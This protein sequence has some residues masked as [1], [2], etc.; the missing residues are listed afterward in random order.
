MSDYAYKKLTAGIVLNDISFGKDAARVADSLPEFR[1]LTTDGDYISRTDL[2][3]RPVLIAFGSISCPMTA[4]AM[5]ALKRLHAQFGDAV[6][7]LMLDVREAHPGENIEQ[8]DTLEAKCRNAT[9]LKNQYGLEFPVAVDDLDGSVHRALGT[10]PNAVFL[11]DATGTIVFRALWASD[12]K[13]LHRAL[14][15]VAAGEAPPQEQSTAMI[16]PF[17]K[18]LGYF[19]A[20]LK[21]AG[22]RAAREV[23]LAAPPIALLAGISRLFPG[24]DPGHRGAAAMASLAIV[25]ALLLIVWL[26]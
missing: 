20:V 7:F 15:A 19:D 21:A 5:P 22:P 11:A 8:P 16:G 24:L 4:S 3:G 9:Q 17:A 18:G 26:T 2:A 12:E 1:L 25:L 10:K 23:L 14:E 13:A 6:R